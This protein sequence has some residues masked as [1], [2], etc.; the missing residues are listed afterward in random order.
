MRFQNE[1]VWFVFFSAMDIML[2]WVILWRGGREVNPIADRV[3][4]AWGLTGAILF[5]F[6]LAVLVIVACEVVARQR[7]PLAR[8]LAVTAV[9][10]SSLPVFYSLILLLR[11]VHF[12]A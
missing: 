10:V 5:K 1:Y 3:I 12:A 8:W 9:A 7:V 6:C 11:H 2:T 4:A